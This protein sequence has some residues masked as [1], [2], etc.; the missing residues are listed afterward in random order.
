M[1]TCRRSIP[2]GAKP[3]PSACVTKGLKA[4]FMSSYIHT[5]YIY[6][7][8][9]IFTIMVYAT[10]PALGSPGVVYD[11]L[12]ARRRSCAH[13]HFGVHCGKRAGLERSSSW[14]MHLA[15]VG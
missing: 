13:C 9:C 4:T 1:Q 15:A 3:D 14:S 2:A 7:A 11:N 10:C 6:V 8:L 5:V 12:K